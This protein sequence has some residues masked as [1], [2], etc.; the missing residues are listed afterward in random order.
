MSENKD[1]GPEAAVK[2]VV[3]DVK[4]KV[5]EAAGAVAGKDELRHEG[6]AQQDKAAAERDV[7]TKEAEAGKRHTPK[8]KRMKLS[9]A[10]PPKLK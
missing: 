10:P 3:E 5:K 7:A 1:T 9:G 2:G 8:L 4:G 6:R